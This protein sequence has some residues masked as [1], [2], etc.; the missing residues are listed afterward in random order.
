MVQRVGGLRR[1]TR[2]KLRKSFKEKGKTAIR[3][4]M[5]TFEEGEKAILAAEPSVQGGMYNL[6]FHGF[7]AEVTGKSGNCYEVRVRDGNVYKT[8]IVNPVHMKKVN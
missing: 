8:L 6:R 3:K 4:F 2:H 7:V 5:Q 1:K